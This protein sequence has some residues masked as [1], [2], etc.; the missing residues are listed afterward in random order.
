MEHWS[1]DIKDPDA[2]VAKI[3][4]RHGGSLTYHQRERLHQFL[5][6]AL[7]ELSKTY[8]PNGRKPNFSG[9]AGTIL[10]RRVTDWRR[11]A[12]EGGRTR[13]QFR[14]SVH[15][16]VIPT[17]VSIDDVEG[18]RGGTRSHVRWLGAAEHEGFVDGP[19]PGA[20]DFLGVLRARSG[21][22]ARPANEVGAGKARRVA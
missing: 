11:T 6:I 17:F 22:D 3:T 20:A 9:H 16:R 1:Y 13:W 5:L 21:Q 8:R 4:V 14:D 19:E 2:F 18:G 10:P 15:E 7:W 12:E